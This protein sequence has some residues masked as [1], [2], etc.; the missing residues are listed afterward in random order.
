MVNVKRTWA[1]VTVALGL[2]GWFLQGQVDGGDGPHHSISTQRTIEE[3]VFRDAIERNPFKLSDPRRTQHCLSIYGGRR[4][5]FSDPD[6][7]TMEAVRHARFTVSSFPS[8]DPK[9]FYDVKSRAS[10]PRID[11]VVVWIQAIQW[12]SPT[13]CMVRVGCNN[14]QGLDMDYEVVQ[15]IGAW[16]VASARIT[17]IE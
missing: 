4:H 11:Q 6:G 3:L 2:F 10:E 16:E 7:R 13:R 5:R 9:W 14:G 1:I 8:C 15:K 17:S 12:L